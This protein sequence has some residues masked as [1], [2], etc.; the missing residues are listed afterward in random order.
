M[1]RLGPRPQSFGPSKESKLARVAIDA[2]W[3]S[4]ANAKLLTGDGVH[5]LSDYDFDRLDSELIA[6]GAERP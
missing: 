5:L 4:P 2:Q 1:Q 3:F 6:A